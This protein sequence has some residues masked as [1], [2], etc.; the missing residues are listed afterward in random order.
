MN[1]AHKYVFFLLLEH[2][3]A[4]FLGPI[5]TTTISN[6]HEWRGGGAS[7]RRGREH[8]L[9]GWDVLLSTLSNN[10]QEKR[11]HLK[12]MFKMA[13]ELSTILAH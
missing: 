11:Q 4:M 9:R 5:Y 6:I 2:G 7:R 1:N 10:S 12:T 8:S 3:T 13:I